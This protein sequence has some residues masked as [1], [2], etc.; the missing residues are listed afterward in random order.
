MDAGIK[1]APL[2][3]QPLS[4]RSTAVGDYAE[5]RQ[6]CTH[7]FDLAG[8]V[9]AHA[10]RPERVRQYD[11]EVT[12]RSGSPAE[13]DA[14]AWRDSELVLAWHLADDEIAAPAEW[15]GAPIHNKFLAWA[16]ANLD[17][18]EAEAAIALKRIVNISHGRVVIDLDEL[19]H[20]DEVGV[21]MH[22]RCH[23]FQPDVAPVAIR[24]RGSARDFTDHPEVL[25][26]D[27][28]LR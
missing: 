25:L 20:A 3:G 24:N 1:L 26:A 10:T 28:D 21:T 5:A 17:P 14:R 6:N 22:Q 18:D 16:E 9:V 4:W 11:F 23:T 15:V 19:E 13:G 27:M 7:M 12:D 2:V 8:L